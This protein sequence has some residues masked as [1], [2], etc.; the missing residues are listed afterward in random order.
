MEFLED[1]MPFLPRTSGR[2]LLASLFLT[3]TVVLLSAATSAQEV[4]TPKYDIFVG[5]QWLHPGG[6]VSAP[7]PNFNSPS[8]MKIPD[9][10]KGFGTAFTYNWTRFLGVEGDFGHNWDNYETTV[11]AGPKL[12]FRREDAN[13]FLHTLLSYNRLDVNGLPTGNG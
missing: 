11:S 8:S 5:Y 4:E 1:D 6:T 12:T 13:Y 3:V 2:V 10:P 7:P 9:M